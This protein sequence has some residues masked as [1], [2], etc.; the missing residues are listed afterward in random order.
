MVGVFLSDAGVGFSSYTAFT[1]AFF[2]ALSSH[3]LWKCEAP[4]IFLFSRT[5]FTVDSGVVVVV[6]LSACSRRSKPYLSV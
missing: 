5:A 3:L 2:W 1:G 4:L 6:D